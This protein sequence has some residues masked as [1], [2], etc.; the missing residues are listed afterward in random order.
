[1]LSEEAR[2]VGDGTGVQKVGETTGSIPPGGTPVDRP[3]ALPVTYD[4]AAL[5]DAERVELR[6][7]RADER[8]L[9]QAA[10]RQHDRQMGGAR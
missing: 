3:A 6:R 7:A 5:S 9:R 1:M 8:R 10:A 4:G 2:P